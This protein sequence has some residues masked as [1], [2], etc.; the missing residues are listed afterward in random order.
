MASKDNATRSIVLNYLLRAEEDANPPVD[1]TL[2]LYNGDPLGAGTVVSGTG[3][4]GQAI[5]FEKSGG[6][7]SSG[8][9]NLQNTAQIDFTC[10]EDV[11]WD[12]VD[13]VAVKDD[14]GRLLYTG[15]LSASVDLS[16]THPQTTIRFAA[17]AVVCSES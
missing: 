1:W 15:A 14:Q 16:S 17:G 5:D 4:T 11:D 9:A 7:A 10:N 3:Y 6:G 13:Y 8:G 2:E 12:V